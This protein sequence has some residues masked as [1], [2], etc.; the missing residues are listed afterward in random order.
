M[1]ALPGGRL[2]RIAISAGVGVVT[3]AALSVAAVAE[4]SAGSAHGRH[5]A[6]AAG[7]HRQRVSHFNVARTHSP[8]VLRELAGHPG[9]PKNG[10]TDNTPGAGLAAV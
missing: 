5:A 9:K 8:K 10:V 6:S 7:H 4:T 2:P 1:W 3:V